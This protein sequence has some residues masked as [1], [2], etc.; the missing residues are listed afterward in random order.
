MK[1]VLRIRKLEDAQ[2]PKGGASLLVLLW[3]EG[4]PEP[5]T[6]AKFPGLVVIIKKP[7]RP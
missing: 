2:S 4:E 5:S 1:T 6:S 3:H 7:A